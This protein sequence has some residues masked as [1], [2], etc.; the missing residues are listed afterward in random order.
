MTPP[1]VDFN[2][3]KIDACFYCGMSG[4]HSRDYLKEN[5]DE[6]KHRNRRHIGHF[7]DIGE[8][9]NDDF[10]NL[11]LYISKLAFSA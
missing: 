9:I 5:F 3:K 10:Q 8:I 11:T 1:K 7:V 6:S 4:D 2:V